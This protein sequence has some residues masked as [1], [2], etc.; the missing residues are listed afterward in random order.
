MIKYRTFELADP[1]DGKITLIGWG[2]RRA[3]PIYK[4][5]W[6]VKSYSL[7][8]WA[9][10]LCELESLGLEPIDTV[11]WRVDWLDRRT[12]QRICH[13]RRCEVTPQQF[14][15]SC[16]VGYVLGEEVV[17]FDTID[18]AWKETGNSL[19]WLRVASRLCTRDS[20]RRRWFTD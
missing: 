15:P 14:N 1:R 7:S 17:H 11:K 18:D 3:T 2:D 19:R 6:A 9:A 12:A 5:L 8:K 13:L 16:P 20:A 4:N 10:W